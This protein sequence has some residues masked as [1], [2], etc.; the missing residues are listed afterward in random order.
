MYLPTR[1]FTRKYTSMSQWTPDHDP[2]ETLRAHRDQ[3]MRELWNVP[4]HIPITDQLLE[5]MRAWT[6][7]F[8]RVNPADAIDL[9]DD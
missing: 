5:D 8:N 7:E 1:I 4:K 6:K 2:I 9:M 3:L